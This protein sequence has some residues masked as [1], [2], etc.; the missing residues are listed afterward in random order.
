MTT[1]EL[2]SRLHSKYNR[3]GYLFFDELSNATGDLRT[4]RAD[5][6]VLGIW[7][8]TGYVLQGF[9]IKTSRADM[10]KEL[11]DVEKWEAIG[12]YCD[13]WW[14]VVSDKSIVDLK[15]LPVVWG[16]MYPTKKRLKVYRPAAK[17]TPDPWPKRFVIAMILNYAKTVEREKAKLAGLLNNK[18]REGYADGQKKVTATANEEHR[19][20]TRSVAEFEETS[21][22]IIDKHNGQYL[23][24][25]VAEYMKNRNRH[26]NLKDT[27][28]GVLA[29]VESMRKCATLCIEQIEKKDG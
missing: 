20:L 28:Q 10:D 16:V 11:N 15:R 9:E 12:K 13:R 24:K 26:A 3:E 1:N 5:A 8:S 7:P 23:G 19:R 25:A 17:L 18:Y 14:L 4:R 27:A 2:F 29:S 6:V 21:G 22:L